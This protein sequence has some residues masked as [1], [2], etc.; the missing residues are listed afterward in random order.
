MNRYL[1]VSLLLLMSFYVVSLNLSFVI[2]FVIFAFTILSLAFTV[3]C[4]LDNKRR[5]AHLKV[6]K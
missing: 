1:Y 6:V 2:A 3:C 4:E 5:R